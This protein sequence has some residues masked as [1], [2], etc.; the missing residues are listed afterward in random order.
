MAMQIA[1]LTKLV[2]SGAIEVQAGLKSRGAAI[3]KYSGALAVLNKLDPNQKPSQQ[4]IRD[5]DDYLSI[6][7]RDNP[8]DN[9]VDPDDIEVD[10]PLKIPS[11]VGTFT[12]VV[13]KKGKEG[14]ELKRQLHNGFC[15]YEED[16]K[17]P[18]SSLYVPL[19]SKIT[20][21]VAED[22]PNLR[23]QFDSLVGLTGHCKI[24][25][26]AQL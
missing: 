10:S 13:K 19:T 11:G 18:I 8:F 17:K 23:N 21:S 2:S 12:I 26:K 22:A 9:G 14:D 20:I 15:L 7:K 24:M 16:G 4:D 25:Q 6:G 3:M 5:H 1:D